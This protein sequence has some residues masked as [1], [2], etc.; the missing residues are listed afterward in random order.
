MNWKSVNILIV[1][2]DEFLRE[3]LADGF[4]ANK[5]NVYTAENGVVAMRILENTQIDFVISDVQ[6]PIMDGF[7]MLLKI[8]ERDSQKPIVLLVTG[9]S[10][11]SRD[12]AIQAGAWDLIIKPFRLKELNSK[13]EHLFKEMHFI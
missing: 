4:K 5:A 1:E 8:R 2:D 7:M 10:D 13:L 11:I 12:K 6:M 3:T 9:H